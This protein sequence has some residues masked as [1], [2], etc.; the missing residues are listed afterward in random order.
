MIKPREIQTKAVYRAIA[1]EARRVGIPFGGHVGPMTELE[2]SE[3]GATIIDHT[4]GD[5]ECSYTQSYAD[6]HKLGVS[7]DI[8]RVLKEYGV[9]GPRKDKGLKRGDPALET[10]WRR[11]AEQFRRN[12]T[13]FVPTYVATG[14]NFGPLAF[15]NFQYGVRYL[16][17][18]DCGPGSS[19]LC[20]VTL[21]QELQR[22]V[23]HGLTPLEALQTAT[24]NPAR[25]WH[26]T[27]SLGTVAPGKLADLV[28]LD[29]NPLADIHNTLTIRAVV[30]NGRYFDRAALDHI[31]AT[32][33]ATPNRRPE[34][35]RP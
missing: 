33:R 8:A 21:H 12:G 11:A 27:D 18:T 25:M 6:L 14:G 22:F 1:V 10:C 34:A 2:A 7:A 32:V 19:L 13:W 20:G 31:R 24:L 28:L 26:A 4:W 3:A 29:A 16:A 9:M 15:A 5:A 17:G 23:Q 30:A 35:R